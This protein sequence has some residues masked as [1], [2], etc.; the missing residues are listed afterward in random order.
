MRKIV[1]TLSNDVPVIVMLDTNIL[2]I[3]INTSPSRIEASLV[4][5]SIP[6]LRVELWRVSACD[7][8]QVCVMKFGPGAR[9]IVGDTKTARTQTTA[10]KRALTVMP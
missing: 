8:A 1:I 9:I 7:S 6:S 10:I 2:D 3:A 5:L 4:L